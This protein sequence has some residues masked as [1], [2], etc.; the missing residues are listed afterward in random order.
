MTVQACEVGSKLNDTR[1]LLV[2]A[3]VADS[4]DEN[5]RISKKNR[6]KFLRS[7]SADRSKRK[8]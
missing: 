1:Q 3:D 4:V 6:E 5:I 8:F 2:C 7:L